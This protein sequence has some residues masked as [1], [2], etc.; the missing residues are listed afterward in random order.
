ML[1]K[2]VELAEKQ[3]ET[4]NQTKNQIASAWA[5]QITDISTKT[6]IAKKQLELS[7]N[8]LEEAKIWLEAL[9]KQKESSLQEIETQISQVKSGKADASVMI[10][11][12]KVVSLIDWVVTKKMAE[13][14][15]VV[16]A[17]TPILVV[18]SD[19]KIKIEVQI[20]DEVLSK[21]K[22]WDKVQ[23]EI[24][25]ISEMKTWELTKILPTRDEITKKWSVEITLDNKWDIKIGSYSKIHFSNWETK[26][27]WKII[28]NTAIL[29][30]MLI[31]GVY[32]IENWKA[33]FKNI[34]IFKQSDNFSEIEWLDIWDEIITDGKE[35]IYDGEDL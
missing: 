20:T 1:E 2:Q 31:P 25:W 26:E 29:W 27:N 17:G 16:W 19:D 12:W 8:S 4:L 13:V 34:T 3:I 6:E 35:N 23:V 11:N 24:E 14:W 28:P 5:G 9:K 21:V 32:V 18:S 10:Q 30:N 22:I 7:Q 15:Q 33:I